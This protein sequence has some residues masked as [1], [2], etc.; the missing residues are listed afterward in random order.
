MDFDKKIQSSS[1]IL[2]G[3]YF[4][5]FCVCFFLIY[6]KSQTTTTTTN[7][8]IFFSCSFHI[9]TTNFIQLINQSISPDHYIHHHIGCQSFVVQWIFY[10]YFFDTKKN[11]HHLNL[12]F[13]CFFK[14]L[15]QASIILSDVAIGK[16][17]WWWCF[18]IFSV[19]GGI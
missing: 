1:D 17:C 16:W 7:A 6:K 8:K 3:F 5:F 4:K 19:D 11:A 12:W 15:L 2:I 13:S 18:F 14:W 9:S 10:F